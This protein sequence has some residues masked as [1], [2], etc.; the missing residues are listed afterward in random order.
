[1]SSPEGAALEGVILG[2]VEPLRHYVQD[3]YPTELASLGSACLIILATIKAE[4]ERRAK[5]GQRIE[6]SALMD[7]ELPRR[8][9]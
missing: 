5:G 9:P 2:D 6:R 8:R 3:A 4:R 1:V 7:P